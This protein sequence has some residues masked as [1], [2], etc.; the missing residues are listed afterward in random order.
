MSARV[1]AA[2][3]AI[4]KYDAQAALSTTYAPNQHHRFEAQAALAAA[5]AVMF[6]DAAV[7]ELAALWERED[8]YCEPG[9]QIAQGKGIAAEELRAV[10]AAL[11]GD[12]A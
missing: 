2:A 11:K 3:K 5:D 8:A 4:H 7:E 12:D 1:D 6:D 10:I 9:D